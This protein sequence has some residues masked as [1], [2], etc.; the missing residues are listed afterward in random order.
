VLL[1]EDVA[2]ERVWTSG[3]Q[4]ILR[5]EI[6]PATLAAAA[7]AV[8]HGLTVLDS[9]PDLTPFRDTDPAEERLIEELT[10]RELEVLSL[11]AEGLTNRAIA[12]QLEI[13]EHTVKFHVNAILSKLNAQ[14]RTEAAV[15]ATRMGFDLL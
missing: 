3:V 9:T 11:L 6:D 2:N 15:R 7:Q 1:P 4:G 8:T 12:Q 14:S 13:S 5:R 10:G